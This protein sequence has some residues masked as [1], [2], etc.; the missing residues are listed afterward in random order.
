MK[1]ALCSSFVPFVSGGYRNIVEWLQVM[2]E[3]Q[4][5]QV[6]K[7]YLPENDA[8]DVLFQ[9]MM[10]YRWVDLEAADRIICFRPQAHLI[11][12]PHKIV[13]FIHHIRIYYDLWQSAYRWFPDDVKHR[14]VRDGLRAVDNAALSEA[15]TIFT[16]SKVVA[17][18]LKTYNHMDSEVLYPPIFQPER[19]YS[20]GHN[21]EIVY[22]SRLEHHKRQHLLIEAMQYTT[23]PIRLRLCGVGSGTYLRDLQH[24][25]AQLQLGERVTIDNHWIS[26]AEKVECLANCLAAAYLPVDEDSY[27]YPSIEASHASKPI[28]TTTDSG[29]V[30]ELIQDGINGYITDPSPKALAEAMDKLFLDRTKTENMG[31]NA[32]DCLVALNIS[33]P[34]VLTRLLA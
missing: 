22:I 11:P 5:H 17:N 29:G 19:F 28:L 8:P 3:E 1:I 34:H 25:V 23:T 20:A 31:R 27:G 7:I 15:K 6:E 21:D 2:L 24:R 26:E 13:W 32:Q 10:A 33:W 9:Q 18:R 16:N 12:H 30:L 14:G 4:G